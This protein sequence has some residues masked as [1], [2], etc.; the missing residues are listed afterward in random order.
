MRYN[1][2]VVEP[3]PGVDLWPRSQTLGIRFRAGSSSRQRSRRPPFH[4][5]P[6]QPCLPR[7]EHKGASSGQAGPDLIA[8][9]SWQDH[10]VENLIKSPHAKLRNIP[11]RAV[12]IKDGFWSQRRK[13]NVSKSI[14][15]MHDLLESNGRTVISGACLLRALNS[16]GLC[17]PTPTSISGRRRW[18]L[19][20]SRATCGI[21]A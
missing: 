19:L 3:H 17:F 6:L 5:F 20:C 8:T 1:A 21:F 18:V 9:P 13:I 11:V 15:T 12:T 14:P 16:M 7:L 4:A 2:S 10:G